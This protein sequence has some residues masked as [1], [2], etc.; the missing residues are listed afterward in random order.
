MSLILKVMSVLVASALPFFLPSHIHGQSL[1]EM[2]ERAVEE[3]NLIQAAEAGKGAAGQAVNQARG[4]WYPHVSGSAN[5]GRE[6]IDPARD[7]LFD[8]ASDKSSTSRTRNIQNLRARQLVYDFGKSGSGVKRASAG[9]ER[10]DAAVSAARQDIMIQGISA[11]LDVYR[12]SQRL[13]LARESE[14]RIIELTG[15]EET[16]VEK[17][18]GLA[19]DVLQAKSQLAG[20]RAMR[21]RMEGQLSN[22]LNRFR[23]VF[24][25]KLTQKQIEEMLIPSRPVDHLPATLEQAL[26]IADKNSLDLHM[27]DL[28]IEMAMHEI[29]FRESRY[30]PNLHLVG[31]ISRKE[32]DAGAR[33][34]R[35]E[36]RGMLELSW[37]IFSGGKDM[38]AVSEA[39]YNM[40]E[41]KKRRDDLNH[42][43]Q[44]R[45]LVAWQNLITSRENARFLRDQAN[46]MEEFLQLAKRE[47][48]LGTR[49]LLDVLNGEVTYLNALSSSISADIDQD[50]AMYDMLYSMGR[51]ELEVLR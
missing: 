47:R 9:L 11:Y 6:Y 26:G 30:F 23:T 28:D 16:L 1:Y 20:A 13:R 35:R 22:A 33:G 36:S 34:T 37:D 7:H 44:E 19:S 43:V 10:S 24:G 25:Y 21:I 45:V 2:L 32:N 41:Q 46:I 27:A 18:A 51:L 42:L 3:H 12:H 48:M 49:S 31:E 39:R 17:G 29:R 15:I 50:M 14:Q 4:E 5:V 40:T 8:S 38:A